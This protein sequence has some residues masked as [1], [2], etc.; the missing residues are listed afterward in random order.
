MSF[1]YPSFLHTPDLG[2]GEWVV[3]VLGGGIS[4]YNASKSILPVD[5]VKIGNRKCTLHGGTADTTFFFYGPAGCTPKLLVKNS[6][7]GWGTGGQNWGN[8]PG[9][10]RICLGNIEWCKHNKPKLG[11]SELSNPIAQRKGRRRPPGRLFAR[12]PFAL[13]RSAWPGA[14]R[15]LAHQTSELNV[16][17]MRFG[18]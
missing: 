3:R 17:L 15:Q 1:V 11:G 8:F 9:A 13:K 16:K 2:S 4:K 18:G 6:Y 5:Y 12:F 14:R 10:F 7:G